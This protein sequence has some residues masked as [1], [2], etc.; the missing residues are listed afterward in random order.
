VEII[1]EQVGKVAAESGGRL[2]E[3]WGFTEAGMLAGERSLFAENGLATVDR[4]HR[5]GDISI[6]WTWSHY[7]FETEL[8]S[9]CRPANRVDFVLSGVLRRSKRLAKPNIRTR[10]ILSSPRDQ[11]SGA[12]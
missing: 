9:E 6:N 5:L 11:S 1:L 7:Q 4:E 2:V 8:Y 12:G 3:S 10:P